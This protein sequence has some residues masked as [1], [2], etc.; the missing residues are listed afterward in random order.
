VF[1]DYQ[2]ALSVRALEGR[3]RVERDPTAVA[4]IASTIRG[5]YDFGREDV[6]NYMS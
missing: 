4:A 1:G 3:A 5:R 2:L 6:A